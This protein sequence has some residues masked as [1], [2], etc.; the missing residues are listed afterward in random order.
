MNVYVLLFLI[1]ISKFGSVCIEPMIAFLLCIL[2][3][4]K[5]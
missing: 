2:G 3:G 5:C 1:T 4:T